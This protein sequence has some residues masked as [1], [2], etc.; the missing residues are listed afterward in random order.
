MHVRISSSLPEKA[1]AHHSGS[2]R[3]PRP[4]PTKSQ[5]P[6]SSSDSAAA[7]DL[8]LHTAITGMD[9]A[10]FTAEAMYFFH[11]SSYVPGSMQPWE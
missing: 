7:G 9:T 10:F 5:A 4:T 2:A 6:S 8:M 3:C 11:P 1:F